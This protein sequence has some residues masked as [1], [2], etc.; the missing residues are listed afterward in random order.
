MGR[1]STTLSSSHS[2]LDTYFVNAD[3]SQTGTSLS[4]LHAPNMTTITTFISGLP[5]YLVTRI[6]R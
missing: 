3:G 6:G 1:A 4:P 5:R 2:P